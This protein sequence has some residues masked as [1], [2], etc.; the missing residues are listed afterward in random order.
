M[1]NELPRDFKGIWLPKEIWLDERLTA[2]DKVILAEIDSLDCGD[3]GCYASNE[4]IANFCQCASSKVSITVSKLKELG[5]IEEV[6][7]DGR[8]RV[9]KSCLLNFKRQPTKIYEA[10][11]QNLKEINIDNNIDNNIYLSLLNK[12]KEKMNE[13]DGTMMGKIVHAYSWAKQQPEFADLT[14]EQQIHFQNDL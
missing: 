6:A 8:T 7:F 2:L 3:K 12:A 9:L 13:Y 4:Y 10:D 11:Y 14:D 5:Y 1:G